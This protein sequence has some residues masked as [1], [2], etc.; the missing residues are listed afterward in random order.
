MY[1]VSTMTESVKSMWTKD[2]SASKNKTQ[3]YHH[4]VISL[5]SLTYIPSFIQISYGLR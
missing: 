2:R 3:Y 4:L 1:I 5:S